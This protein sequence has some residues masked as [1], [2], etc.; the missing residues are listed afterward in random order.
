MVRAPLV[1]QIIVIQQRFQQSMQFNMFFVIDIHIPQGNAATRHQVIQRFAQLRGHFQQPVKSGGFHAAALPQYHAD[2][3]VFHNAD[4]G[5]DQIQLHQ[6]RAF[7][8]V[9]QPQGAQRHPELV[10]VHKVDGPV[11]LVKHQLHP[12]FRG[13]MG[14]L[15]QQ[16]FRASRFRQRLLQTQ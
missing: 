5:G 8:I 7:A 12:E 2:F 4:V 14:H 1:E 16:L 3:P 10:G 11:Q 13:L 6:Q 15:K 9:H